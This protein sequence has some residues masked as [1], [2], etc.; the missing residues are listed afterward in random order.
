MSCRRRRRRLSPEEVSPGPARARRS[1]PGGRSPSTARRLGER[2][3]R[4]PV[5]MGPGTTRKGGDSPGSPLRVPTL[6]T[7]S[8]DGVSEVTALAEA[9]APSGRRTNRPVWAQ[10]ALTVVLPCYN[11]AERLPG[12]LQT[13]LAHLSQD[14]AQD[15]RVR[16]LSCHPNHGKGFAVRAGMLAA[17]GELIVFTDADGSYG[18]S[19]PTGSS[20]R[21]TR[22]R[23]RSESGPLPSAAR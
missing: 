17:E 18:S 23:W 13:L 3:L 10:P 12:T 11:E 6:P 20:E 14:P 19:E 15:G 5:L 7:L 1:E 9:A 2:G 22:R 16:V 8:W 21:S 4:T